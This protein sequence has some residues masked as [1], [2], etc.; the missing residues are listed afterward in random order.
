MRLYLSSYLWGNK[1]E[2]LFALLGEDRHAAI[3]TNSADQFPEKGV[4]ER[5][6]ADQEYLKEQG[7]TSER[8]DLR[9]YF[10]N[11]A[12]LEPDLQKFGLVWVKGANVFVLR[13]AFA[14]SGFDV[15]LPKLLERDAF[16]YG[17]YSA[18]ACI[19]GSTLRGLDL[20]DDAGLAPDGY[21]PD[22]IWDGLGVLPY[23]VAPHFKSEHP[24]SVLIN[25]SVNYFK[26]HAI[27][28][29]ALHDGEAIVINGND[30]R[31]VG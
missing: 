30:H 27:P 1:P 7:I 17:G 18:G 16:T 28:Y 29:K 12:K 21:L 22:T 25:D 11:R 23:A 19:M 6:V 8:L 13:R 3:I 20:V 5:L 9:E 10:S 15:L 14:Q 26:T 31:I 2:A 4:V 24:E